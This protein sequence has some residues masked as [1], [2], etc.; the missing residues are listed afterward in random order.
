MLPTTADVVVIG[1]GVMGTSA[2]YHLACTRHARTSCCWKRHP[3]LGMEATG[4]CA[5]GIRYQF[6]T[7]INV[8]LSLLSLP[9]L[10]RFEEELGQA[11]DLRWPGYL[12]L[13]DNEHDLAV[14]RNNVAL[15]NRLGIPSRILAP[16]GGRGESPAAQPGGD[17]RRGAGTTGTAWP[18]PTAWCRATP[19]ARGTW[20]RRSSPSVEVTGIRVEV[21]P[22]GRGRDAAGDHR[23]PRRGQRRRAVGGQ[24]GRAGR[25]RS[26][27]RA[28]APPDRRSR[29]RC[30]GIP[31]DFPFV[32]DFS[33]SLY[34]HREGKGILTGQ[35]N[36]N[37]TPGFDQTI[38]HEWTEQH[39]ERAM[40]RFPLLERAGL[41]REWAGLYEVTPD[42]HPVID[43]LSRPGGL[44]RRRRASAVTASCTAPSPAC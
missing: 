12:F 3:F 38:D 2:A 13:L 15:Q 30:K 44:L 10:E 17:H 28:A 33:R 11:I 37:E 25:G 14:F 20:A 27:H 36:P 29:R 32:L 21:G 1:G 31:D 4:K 24:G 8:R 42:A 5:G 34:F 19:Q 9:M 7:E 18:I 26:A 43:G 23:H 35:S 41:L 6:S 40:W 39:L 16:D 22:R